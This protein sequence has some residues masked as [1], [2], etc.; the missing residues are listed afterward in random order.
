MALRSC[1]AGAVIVAINR[2]GPCKGDALGPE[3][4]GTVEQCQG[5]ATAEPGT[6]GLVARAGHRFISFSHK[7]PEAAMIMIF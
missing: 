5:A 1:L 3:S 4:Q 6:L 2:S 7:S